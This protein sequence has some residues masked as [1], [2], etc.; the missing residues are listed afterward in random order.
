MVIFST[1]KYSEYL[2]IF[3]NRGQVNDFYEALFTYAKYSYK[4]RQ[5]MLQYLLVENSV[6]FAQYFL[7]CPVNEVLKYLKKKIEF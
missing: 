6:I 1:L 5:W 7:D 2:F 4:A 3:K